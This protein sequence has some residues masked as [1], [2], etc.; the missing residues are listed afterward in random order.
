MLYVCAKCGCIENTALGLYWAK[1][2][3]ELFIWDESNIEFRGKALCSECAPKI[4]SNNKPTELG[5]WHNKWPKIHWR[6]YFKD[7]K[8]SSPPEGPF[9]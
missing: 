5:T 6:E 1:S 4:Y 8:L 3:P 9:S 2:R 7:Q